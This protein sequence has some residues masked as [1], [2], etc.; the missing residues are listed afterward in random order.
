MKTFGKFILFF[1]VNLLLILGVLKTI[2]MTGGGHSSASLA[3]AAFDDPENARIGFDHLDRI[4]YDNLAPKGSK[5][6]QPEYP[7]EILALDGKQF[8]ML[9][10]MAAY[11]QTSSYERFL[12]INFPNECNFCEV[13]RLQ[14]ILFV[15]SDPKRPPP[16]YNGIVHVK[17]TLHLRLPGKKVM[18]LGDDPVNG[19]NLLDE[20]LVVIKNA[21]VRPWKDPN[22]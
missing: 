4:K 13:D 14:E 8:E 2:A 22:E 6:N 17:G 5:A 20:F 12:L 7:A 15:E 9:G 16:P 11:D 1:F 18:V 3:R 19:D 10:F 21:E